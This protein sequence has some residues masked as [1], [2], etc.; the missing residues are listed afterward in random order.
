M[1]LYIYAKIRNPSKYIHNSM[2]FE[3]DSPA[4]IRARSYGRVIS[5][6]EGRGRDSVVSELQHWALMGQVEQLTDFAE[7]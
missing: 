2:N 4:T 1:P 6:V 3:L 7:L 5:L